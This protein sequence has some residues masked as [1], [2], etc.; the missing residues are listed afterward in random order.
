MDTLSLNEH[1]LVIF[2]PILKD[3]RCFGIRKIGSFRWASSRCAD[4]IRFGTINKPLAAKQ[5]E[6]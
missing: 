1:N 4:L 6:S 2:Q 5:Q 3:Y